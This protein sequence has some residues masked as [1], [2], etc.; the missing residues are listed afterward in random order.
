MIAEVIRMKEENKGT[1][2]NKWS[3]LYRKKWFFPAIYL[4]V[5]ALLLS[6]V[7]WFQSTNKEEAAEDPAKGDLYEPNMHDED[8]VPV[9]DQDEVI[10]MPVKEDVKAQVVTKFYDYDAEKEERL[11]ALVFHNSR[12]YQS[13]GIDLRTEDDDAFDV[14]ASLSGTVAEIKED[15]LLGNVVSLEHG[16][17]VMTYYASLGEVDVKAGDKVKQGDVLGTA[18]KN[19]FGKDNGV[20]VHFELRKNDQQVN[21]EKY[22]NQPVSKIEVKEE[23]PV[24]GAEEPSEEP[25]KEESDQS[26]NEDEDPQGDSNEEKSDEKPSEDEDEESENDEASDKNAESDDKQN[27][28]PLNDDKKSDDEKDNE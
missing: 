2:K 24:E 10:Q 21:P 17:E 6:G 28:N 15:P 22:F 9:M 20:H 8:A 12:Y 19:L 7:I 1:P 26:V 25:S 13:T 18:G 27:D 3:H 4:G 5:A 16:D 11:D 14:L 23:Q